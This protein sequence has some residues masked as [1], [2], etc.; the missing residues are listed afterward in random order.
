[1]ALDS[2]VFLQNALIELKALEDAAEAH[3]H[4]VLTQLLMA[5]RRE[6]EMLLKEEL[7]T[8]AWPQ[9]ADERHVAIR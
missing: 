2:S 7:Q 1:M 5:A 8:R 4:G 6:A 9:S 3:C